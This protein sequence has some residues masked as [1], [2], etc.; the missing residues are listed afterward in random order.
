MAKTLLSTVR[1][2]NNPS[3]TTAG[4][5]QYW[6]LANS[7]LLTSSTEAERE[8]TYR[9]AGTLSKL[10][11]RVTAN[12]A[13]ASSTLTVRKN[14]AD[15][16]MTVTIGAAATGVFEDTSNTVTVA[17]GDELCY[18]TV[19]GGT[20]TITFSIMSVVF[21]ATTNCVSK[22]AMEGYGVSAASTTH[23][24]HISG[25]R[26]GTTATESGQESTIKEAGTAKNAAIY[27]SANA[28]T[29]DTTFTLRKNR[30]DTAIVLT[31]GSGVTGM[32]EDTSNS[33][34]YAVDDELNW[35]ITSGTGTETL[36]FQTLAIEYETTTNTGFISAGSTGAS[37]DN[38]VNAAVTT[39][40]A[41][42][43]SHMFDTTEDNQKQ[44]ARGAFTLKNLV[45][46]PGANT[47]TADSTFT[48]RKNGADTSL[49]V[50][51]P[52]SATG[53]HFDT[54]HTE[55]VTADDELSLKLIT[56][57]TG[58]S[59]TISHFSICTELAPTP[60]AAL[61]TMTFLT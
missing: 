50:T 22:M 20:G 6:W 35:E 44:K 51:I 58:T 30:V 27:V 45:I 57:A 8:I 1:G 17:A 5:T 59:M 34:A 32:I 40:A 52:A 53:F 12:S 31:V 9:T 19:S 26:S 60:E 33:V 16:A 29:T 43:G 37:A 47:V 4:A 3:V 39:Y 36:T 54:T 61:A 49:V 10:Y 21:D 23:F 13:S 42:G 56:G 15:T 28:R 55:T 7:S 46:R 38:P 18:K 2:R 41:I 24:I 25:D 48:L 11:V 14:A